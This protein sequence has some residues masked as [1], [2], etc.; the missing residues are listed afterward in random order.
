[1]HPSPLVTPEALRRR[2]GAPGLVVLDASWHLP[3]AGRDPQAEFTATRIPGA[4]FFDL[5][6]LSDPATTL[7]H[8][9]PDPARFEDGVRRLG[10][11]TASDVVVYDASGVNLSAAR[12]WWMF[13]A[14]GHARVAVLDGGLGAWLAAG[15][16]TD[17]G[18]A[19]APPSGDFRARPQPELVRSAEEVRA[20]LAHGAQVVDARPAG[21]FHGRDPEPRPGL[22]G[23]HM[24]GALSL[25]YADLVDATGRM[26]PDDALRERL[27]RAG[28][29][30]S[31]PVIATCG[32]G[33]SAC[34][35]LLALACLEAP[36]GAL[37]DGSWAEWGARDDLP[38]SAE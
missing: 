35:V 33:T 14:Y 10:V 28:V 21:R 16:P 17:S 12:A 4:R 38:V 3:Q 29:D 2:L 32:S 20:A 30:P 13:R 22:R 15:F 31:R 7:P 36:D 1:M 23:G 37:Y 9:L 34:A 6:A 26:L 11:G 5:D 8:M 24:P 18:A 27:R 19:T 25:P